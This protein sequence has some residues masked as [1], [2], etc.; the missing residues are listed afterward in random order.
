ME[1]EL[2]HT[3]QWMMS[4]Y[5]H[6]MELVMRHYGDLVKWTDVVRYKKSI[7]ELEDACV[8]AGAAAGVVGAIDGK[9]VYTCQPGRYTEFVQQMQAQYGAFPARARAAAPRAAR[10]R[11]CRCRPDRPRP[12]AHCAERLGTAWFV[13]HA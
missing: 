4:V 3:R 7:E 2:R 9:P 11:G 8:A 1:R 5:Y 6:T 10:V 12:L 13:R